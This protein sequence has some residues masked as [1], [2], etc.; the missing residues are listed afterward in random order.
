[1][2]DL[3][4][5]Y[6]YYI[7][8]QRRHLKKYS[9]TRVRNVATTFFLILNRNS[10]GT[11]NFP[12]EGLCS[13]TGGGLYFFS[14]LGTVG[15]IFVSFPRQIYKFSSTGGGTSTPRQGAVAPPLQP[16]LDATTVYIK[17]DKDKKHTVKLKNHKKYLHLLSYRSILLAVYFPKRS[18]ILHSA[19]NS[20]LL[21]EEF[22]S[23]TNFQD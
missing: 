2:I 17:P 14:W 8:L 19:K 16:S 21:P 5:K 3:Q 23:M 15:Q 22:L 13:P 12:T 10:G 18:N 20:L 6:R 9:F 4:N 1:M 11:R 7:I